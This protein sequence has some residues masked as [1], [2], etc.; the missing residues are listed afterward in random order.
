MPHTTLPP[1]F[2]FS[3]SHAISNRWAPTPES[4]LKN[5]MHFATCIFFFYYCSWKVFS[6]KKFSS[7][8]SLI[9]RF[10]LSS[11]PS[12]QYLR[13]PSFLPAA[14]LYIHASQQHY[15]SITLLTHTAIPSIPELLFYVPPSL[16]QS[17]SLRGTW[18][19][20]K[21]LILIWILQHMWWSYTYF[22]DMHFLD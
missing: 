3:I 14:H 6:K 19:P 9:R 16:W 2:L 18:A 7:S 4:L 8:H 12:T 11:F 21:L 22:L 1:L 15:F 10:P 20:N 5:P 13:W 17:G